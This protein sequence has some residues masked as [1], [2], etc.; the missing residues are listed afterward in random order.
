MAILDAFA[1][2]LH[3][4]AKPQKVDS[5]A[6]SWALDALNNKLD[7]SVAGMWVYY[8]LTTARSPEALEHLTH[9]E[10]LDSPLKARILELLSPRHGP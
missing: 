10:G 6:Q 4:S 5:H 7:Q 2:F 1:R 9:H 8:R 3:V